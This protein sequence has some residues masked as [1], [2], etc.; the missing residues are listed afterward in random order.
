MQKILIIVDMQNDFITG[1][2]GTEEA[3]AIIPKILRKILDYKPSERYITMD[4]HF[5]NYLTTQEGKNLPVSHCI[6]GTEGWELEEHIKSTSVKDDNIICKSSFGCLGLI[7][8]IA[9]LYTQDTELKVELVG[10]CTDICVI[11]NALLIKSAFPEVEITVDASCCAGTTPEKHK[12]ALE[13]MKSCQI[14]VINEGE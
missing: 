11:S 13:V 4:T 6:E 12:A 1:A 7:N 3:K 5:D 10:V 2:L 8:K 14:N 9:K